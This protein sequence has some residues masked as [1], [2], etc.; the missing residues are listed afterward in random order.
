MHNGEALTDEDR[1]PWLGTLNRAIRSWIADECVVVFACSALR[2]W[3]RNALR[4]GVSSP[5]S[6]RFVYL[7]GRMR[8][9]TAD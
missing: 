8:R 4:E 9:S 1:E 5:D 7:K 6:I 3:H 2:E